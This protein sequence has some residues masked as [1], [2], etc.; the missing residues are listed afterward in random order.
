MAVTAKFK[1]SRITPWGEEED[2]N[3]EYEFTPDYAEGKNAE[4]AKFT[5]AGV[6]RMTVNNPAAK[7]QFGDEIGKSFTVVLDPE[8]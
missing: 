1:L 2:S 8:N 3:V 6:L 7:K 5:P 4:W